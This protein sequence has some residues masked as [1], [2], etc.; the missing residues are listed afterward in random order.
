MI[1]TAVARNGESWTH[2]GHADGGT[3]AGFRELLRAWLNDNVDIDA[4]RLC[5]IVLAT[6]EALS[7]VV[8]HA[9]QDLAGAGDVTL[10]LSHHATE[11]RIDIRVRD[12]GHWRVPEPTPISAIRGRG[13]ILMRSL[14]D[15]CTVAGT[16]NGTTVTLTF[17]GCPR[18]E[19]STARLG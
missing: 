8:D 1:E 5:D 14:A 18:V 15:A 6:D 17:H 11:A 4:E 16:A 2:S 13:L 19:D 9:Y 3:V 7:N 10:D 12:Q